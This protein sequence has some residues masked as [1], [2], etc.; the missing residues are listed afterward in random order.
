MKS[1][2][3]IRARRERLLADA[4]RQRDEIARNYRRNESTLQGAA[5]LV[6]RGIGF[7]GWLRKRPLVLGVVTAV[8]VAIRPRG[9]LKLAG[10]GLIAWRALR[11]IKGFLKETGVTP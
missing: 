1:I 9:A 5:G 4:A 10:R 7:V 8:L 6:D 3:E 11:A 2:A